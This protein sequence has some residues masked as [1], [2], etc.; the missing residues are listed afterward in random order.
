[1][2]A[3]PFSLCIYLALCLLHFAAFPPRHRAWRLLSFSF[4]LVHGCVLASS[5][6]GGHKSL[7][8]PGHSSCLV[9][10]SPL[11]FPILRSQAR[12]HGRPQPESTEGAS[13]L[14]A[15]RL[16]SKRGAEISPIPV[17]RPTAPLLS[18][19]PMIML[20]PLSA[21]GIVSEIVWRIETAADR[22]RSTNLINFF[23]FTQISVSPRGHRVYYIHVS[24]TAAPAEL[25]FHTLQ[26]TRFARK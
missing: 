1:M 14:G 20:L 4:F 25:Q 17:P 2:R 12:R 10:G 24:K 7:A 23:C 16:A 6:V 5:A 9:P 21:R 26:N 19:T 11:S 8:Q 15:S 22:G 18:H 3:L 13:S